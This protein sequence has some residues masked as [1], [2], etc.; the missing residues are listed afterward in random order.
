MT[1]HGQINFAG[2]PD[3]IFNESCRWTWPSKPPA[4]LRRHSSDAAGQRVTPYDLEARSAS[5]SQ[6]LR[7]FF[8]SFLH[9]PRGVSTCAPSQPDNWLLRARHHGL[10]ERGGGGPTSRLLILWFSSAVF[11][12]FYHNS[13]QSMHGNIWTNLIAVN[14]PSTVSI[15]I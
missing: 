1:S 14:R 8:S 13:C 3:D 15:M 5:G 12:T 11:I 10:P 4:G 7:T 2:T 9:W 6:W